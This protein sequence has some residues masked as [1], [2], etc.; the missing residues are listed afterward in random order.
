MNARDF[1]K[2]VVEQ[3]GSKDI[4]GENKAELGDERLRQWK[5]G[6]VSADA[7]I[8]KK[9]VS[10]HDW[11]SEDDSDD[12]L[13]HSAKKEKDKL[14]F[15]SPEKRTSIAEQVKY[16]VN[17]HISSQEYLDKLIIENNGDVQKAQ[18]SQEQ[19]IKML[20]EVQINANVQRNS[21]EI[22]SV[23]EGVAKE[24]SI[25]ASLSTDMQSKLLQYVKDKYNNKRTGGIYDSTHKSLYIFDDVRGKKF[26]N[27]VRHE[28]LHGSTNMEEDISDNAKKILDDTFQGYRNINNRSNIREYNTYLKN[29]SERLVRKQQL[30]KQLEELG[31]KKY[32]EEFTREHFEKMSEAY[33]QKKFS[34]DARQF[35]ET[36]NPDFE[37][38]KK[39][40]DTI[41]DTETQKN[42]IE[43]A[44]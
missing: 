31:I 35:L 36:T 40:F 27:A 21:E 25:F 19:R 44:A 14:N 3:G 18:E 7:K 10:G 9:Q 16:E 39:I 34:E 43:M 15:D 42:D 24:T 2:K 13:R 23:L 28:L 29:H 17:E 33:E 4:Q 1:E 32:E 8:A 26:T 41:A 37:T 6:E 5:V 12:G 38:Y 11:Y 30:D 22:N 20:Q